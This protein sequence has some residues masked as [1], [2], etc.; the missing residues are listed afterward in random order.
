MRFEPHA[1]QLHAIRRIVEGPAVGLFLDMGLGKT[2]IALTAVS[3]LRYDR[4]AV[5]RCLV[6]APKRVAESTW[7]SEAG[8]WD[9]LRL[10]RV[11]VATGPAERRL[12]ALAAPADVYV[13]GRD[14]VP[15]LVGLYRGRPWPFDML[16]VD[17]SSGFKDPG[18]QRF[19]ALRS[20]RPQMS[21]AVLL[22]GTPAP[23][24][25]LGLWAQ[26]WLLDQGERL[27]R[28]FR[29][30][31]GRWFDSDFRGYSWAPKPGAEEA[32]RAAVG[33]ICV[34][35]RSEDYLELPGMVLAE[36]PVV[37]GPGAM[38]AY[39]RLE[40][41]A[42]LEAGGAVVDAGSAA[43]LSGKLLQLCNGAVYAEGGEAVEVHRCKVDS[44]MELVE[45]LAGQPALVFYSFRHDLARLKA[46]LRGTGL[47]VRELRSPADEAAWNRREA[48]ILLA[49]PA[50]AAYGLNLQDGG[51]Q[52]V[53]F[54]LCWSLELYSQANRRLH[55]QGQRQ[56]V[57]VHH[58]VVQGGLDEDVM[59]ALRRKGAS[60][61]AL[62]D[63]L[64]ARVARVV[65]GAGR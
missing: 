40:R 15:W 31:R 33:D 44:F 21:R 14:C 50:S 62:V 63:G 25:L 48:D 55:R 27:G 30:F 11:S 4:F 39:R 32:I 59:A 16:V 36:R 1:Y 64:K 56:V 3:Q 28:S 29:A 52:V 17:E 2:A 10:L 38:A 54:G 20:V 35:M 46:A 41:E 65:A 18:S 6:V 13:V 19:R 45:G 51:N 37:L 43:A 12:R 42:V 7:A 49:H 57:F 34:S 9:H 47:R 53:W 22:T 24:G 58:L 60:Q 23:N 8:K 61:D 5:G 26:L